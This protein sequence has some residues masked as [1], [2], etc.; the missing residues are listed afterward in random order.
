MP[1]ATRS[2]HIP[3]CSINVAF[4]PKNVGTISGQL[5]VSDQYRTQTVTLNGIGVAP[6]GVS[7]SPF[8]T[9]T[10]PAT[11]VGVTSA[12]Q[13][14]TLTNNGGVPLLV[15]SIVIAGDFVIVPGTNTCGGTVAVSAAC[16]M[17]I[18]FVPTVGG[19]R[20]GT[21][22][23]TDNAA[24]SPQ[25]LSLVG[26]GIDFTLDPNGG[27]SLTI[28]NGQNAVYPLLLSSAANVTGTVSFTCTGAPANSTCN[29]TPSSVA[30]GNATTVSVTVLTGVS[31][32]ART[33]W[34]SVNRPNMFWLATLLPLSFVALSQGSTS[35]ACE[36]CSA[37]VSGCRNRMRCGARDSVGEWFESKPSV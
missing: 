33:S 26:S 13:T 23:V 34:P 11:G 12:A 5:A 4:E 16:T 6:P 37:G 1:A 24:N 29:V 27:T 25:T 32:T 2:I 15:Q 3:R 17:Q 18:A 10:F 21:L 8:S 35:V 7:L 31:S 20:A 28:A 14:V 19:P 30:L 9:V 36:G 22:T